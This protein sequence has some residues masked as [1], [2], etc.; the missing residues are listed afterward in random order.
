MVLLI[1]ITIPHLQLWNLIL[2][3]VPIGK[4]L[5]L[6]AC[7]PALLLLG[8]SF[9]FSCSLGSVGQDT[10][11]CLWELTEDVIRQG[12]RFSSRYYQSTGNSRQYHHPPVESLS[13]SSSSACP[14]TL[15]DGFE[16][17][18]SATPSNA[19]SNNSGRRK[20]FFGSFR[21]PL[22]LTASRYH[23]EQSD[24]SGKS[25]IL[26][27]SGCLSLPGDRRPLNAVNGHALVTISSKELV[28][29]F[30]DFFL[31]H[32]LAAFCHLSRLRVD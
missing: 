7:F 6:L 14:D 17:S 19:P 27:D 25:S 18:R 4:S 20:P 12:L 26:S 10:F 29:F 24:T 11:L 9:Q 22:P 3:F 32:T 16:K 15:V 2:S 28:H 30:L 13:I 1:N 21:S 31:I 5:F 8:S 23:S